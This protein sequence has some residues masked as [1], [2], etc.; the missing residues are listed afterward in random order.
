MW[1]AFDRT[2]QGHPVLAENSSADGRL[3]LTVAGDLSLGGEFDSFRARHN[4]PWDYPFGEVR[5]LFE[6]ADIRFAN[7]ECCLLRNTRQRPKD[8][9]LS[10]D[11]AAIEALTG[12][13]LD[14]VSVANN[15]I[16]DLGN[17][18]V[19]NTLAV[20][21]Q[22]GIEA[23]GAGREGRAREWAYLERN[24]LKIAF[25][26]YCDTGIP[27][28]TAASATEAGC[29]PLDEARMLADIAK[30]R[31]RA[32]VVCVSVHWGEQYFDYPSPEQ[33]RL[34][35]AM[36][37]AGAHVVIGHHPHVVQGFERY[38]NGVIFYSL[39]N[40]LLPDFPLQS[41]VVYRSPRVTRRFLVG[42]V[43]LRDGKVVVVEPTLGEMG[44]DFRL[45]VPG[46]RRQRS[47]MHALERLSEPLQRQDYCQFWDDYV[48]VGKRGV[49]RD[50]RRHARRTMFHH[51]RHRGLAPSI[52]AALRRL[53]QAFSFRR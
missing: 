16:A 52:A 39:G 33:V 22:A 48:P 49:D 17:E 28:T 10:T 25:G 46:G 13:G 37:D 32:E 29:N 30:A 2:A 1:C 40:F 19:T 47:L 4:L 45:P 18:G 6:S 5:P 26:A 41:G 14:V 51:V 23:V 31:A 3:V 24:G 50:W 35:R 8:W 27:A 15:H 44:P 12:L 53:L 11:P 36:V 9:L 42:R 21:D 38:G 20:L 43:T 7:L 34:G